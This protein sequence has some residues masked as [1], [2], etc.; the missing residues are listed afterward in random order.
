MP[1]KETAPS[2]LRFDPHELPLA[3]SRLAHRLATAPV[4]SSGNNVGNQLPMRGVQLTAEV[5]GRPA[6]ALVD[7]NR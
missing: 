3:Y 2:A 4:G 1:P 7:R 6:I 5:A